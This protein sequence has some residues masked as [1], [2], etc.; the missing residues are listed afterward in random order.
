MNAFKFSLPS[1]SSSKPPPLPPKDPIYLQRGTAN[2]SFGSLLT[3]EPSPSP[4]ALNIANGLPRHGQSYGS[5]G[6]GN[7][8]PGPSPLLDST[9]NK[10]STSVASSPKIRSNTAPPASSTVVSAGGKLANGLFGKFGRKSG[11]RSPGGV[12]SQTGT[13]IGSEEMEDIPPPPQEDGNISLPWG[14]SVRLHC[15]F[16]IILTLETSTTSTSTRVL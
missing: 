15:L 16:C 10:S 1:S 4:T 12:Q 9:R 13:M 5:S 3:P 2:R 14:F 11:P 6:T 8:S 7:S